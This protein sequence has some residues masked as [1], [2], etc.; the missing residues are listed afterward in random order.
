MNSVHS[1]EEIL[2][3]VEALPSMPRAVAEIMRTIDDENTTP[4]ML[5]RIIESDIGLLAG[6]LKLVN[7]SY[8][9]VSGGVSSPHQAVIILGFNTIRNLAC[10]EG[11]SSFFRKNKSSDFNFDRFIR[12][13]IAVACCAKL[14]ARELKLNTEIAFVA[15]LL[16]DVGQ[17][18]VVATL[19]DMYRTV[20]EYKKLHG[21][22]I[23]EAEQVVMGTDHAQIG[24]HLVKRWNFPIEI[25][26]AIR[27]HHQI[28]DPD[29]DSRMVD[30]IHVSEVLSHALDLGVPSQLQEDAD[31]VPPLSDGAMHRLKLSFQQLEPLFDEIED[32]YSDVT[33]LLGV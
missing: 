23:S 12:H 2:K 18:A 27:C 4:E 5:A 33:Q 16:H 28:F 26:D 29:K 11:I 10:S 31:Q 7:S 6:V 17:L 32:E 25:S 14:L 1:V 24:A 3:S 22:H 19:P 8:Y 13:S 15:G 30:L 21:C 20:Q 9:A